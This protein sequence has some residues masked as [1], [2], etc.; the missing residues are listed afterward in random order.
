MPPPPTPPIELGDQLAPVEAAGRGGG[1]GRGV[2]V[3]GPAAE[4]RAEDRAAGDAADRAGDQLRQQ[5]HPA[6]LT[7]FPAIPPPTAP[8]IA[9]TMIATIP[10]IVSLPSL[11]RGRGP[12]AAAGQSKAHLRSS[13]QPGRPGPNAGR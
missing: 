12:Q 6:A 11:S 3:D 8:A 1:V 10:S 2:R 9:W 5:R 13:R 7:M 4:E